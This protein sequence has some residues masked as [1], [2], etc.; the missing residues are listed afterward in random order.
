MIFRS[1][2]STPVRHMWQR[3]QI[4]IHNLLRN[5]FVSLVLSGDFVPP[6]VARSFVPRHV[7]CSSNT[8]TMYTIT[9][10]CSGAPSTLLTETLE[11]LLL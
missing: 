1:S 2:S 8:M 3:L 11:I 6:P 5:I 4:L 9:I 7:R 10:K